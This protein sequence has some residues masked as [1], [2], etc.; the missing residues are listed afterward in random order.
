MKMWMSVLAAGILG[1]PGAGTAQAAELIVW[2]STGP[3]TGVYELAAGFEK[4]T[5]NK[6]TV[7][8]EVGAALTR[9]LEAN[10]PVDLI[11]GGSELIEDLIK[12]GKVVAGSNTPFG[13]AGLGISVKAGAPRPDISTVEG[14]KAV[15]LAAKSIGY[16]RGCSGIHAAEGIARLGIAEQMKPKTVL[17]AGVPV[18]QYL[19]K[20]DF[21]IGIQQTNELVGIPGTDYV[22]PLP[23]Y[24]NKP[25]PFNVGLIAVSKQQ[26]LARAMIKFMTSQ[27]GISLLQKGHME[28]VR[29]GS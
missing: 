20:G 21:E 22:G 12:K 5:G 4:A 8:F 6:V 24:L 25:C 1:S 16:S 26:D 2:T 17:T 9:K 18:A 14:Y 11:A 19:A 15:L 28:P 13:I 23:G 29:Q 10:A 7:S 27:D 3:L